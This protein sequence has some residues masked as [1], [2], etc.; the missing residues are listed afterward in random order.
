MEPILDAG[1]GRP[2]GCLKHSLCESKS[3]QTSLQRQ[4]GTVCLGTMLRKIDL[5]LSLVRALLKFGAGND[6]NSVLGRWLLK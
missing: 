4:V 3:L 5:M 2:Q 1:K 6:Q